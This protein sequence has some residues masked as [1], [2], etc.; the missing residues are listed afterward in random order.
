M[1]LEMTSNA[2]QK[3]FSHNIH[4]KTPISKLK[5]PKNSFGQNK[6]PRN[7]KGTKKFQKTGH[8]SLKARNPKNSSNRLLKEIDQA[9]GSS[10]NKNSTKKSNLG[11]KSKISRKPNGAGRVLK[12]LEP[13][14]YLY[15]SLMGKNK[16]KTK[17]SAVKTSSM[18]RVKKG[19]EEILTRAQAEAVM[20]RFR[21]LFH[22][23]EVW[24]KYFFFENNF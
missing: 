6:I 15:Q 11:K 1:Q 19:D 9:L 13:K 20:D 7:H 14:N 8:S 3:K 24:Y 17:E 10:G 18:R 16:L 21:Q 5:K 4:P 2:T 12:E 22:N 23:F